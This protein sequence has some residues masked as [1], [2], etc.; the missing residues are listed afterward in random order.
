MKPGADAA[1]LWAVEMHEVLVVLAA[2]ATLVAKKAAGLAFGPVRAVG[3]L[4]LAR[5][6]ADVAHVRALPH[7]RRRVARAFVLSPHQAL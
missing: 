6:G 4:V 5:K 7:D 2:L 1:R 3:V